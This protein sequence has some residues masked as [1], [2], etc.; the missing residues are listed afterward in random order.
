MGVGER[1][2][3]QL[4]IVVMLNDMEGKSHPNFHTLTFC[5][6]T[7]SRPR[8]LLPALLLNFQRGLQ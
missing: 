5:L 3:L 1:L 4:M 8:T 6:A 7:Y 2:L